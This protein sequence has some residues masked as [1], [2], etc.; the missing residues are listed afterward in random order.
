MDK[1]RENDLVYIDPPYQG[2]CGGCD[3]RYASV[4]SSDRF[5]EQLRILSEKRIRFILSYDGRMGE[6]K[7]GRELPDDLG[8]H[9]IEIEV[10]R[11]AQATLLGKNHTTYESIYLSGP[12]LDE[13]RVL[14]IPV[15]ENLKYY[16]NRQMFLIKNT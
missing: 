7:Y 6:I 15:K 14:R 1:V 16:D 11:S 3:P 9:R 8:L 12:L 5:L 2:I 13:L 10:G 4:I